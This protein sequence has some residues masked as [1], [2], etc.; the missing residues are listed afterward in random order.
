MYLK[1]TSYWNHK[2]T[3]PNNRIGAHKH[4]HPPLGVNEPWMSCVCWTPSPCLAQLSF[5]VCVTGQPA[6]E[7]PGTQC[8][9]LLKDLQSLLF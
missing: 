3:E 7:Q 8:P 4:R 5:K 2:T 6:S 1:R 9:P